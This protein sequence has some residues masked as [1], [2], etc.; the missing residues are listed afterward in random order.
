M[1]QY[2]VQTNKK[3][4]NVN[5]Q[6]QGMIQVVSREDLVL[7]QTKGYNVS[8]RYT[9]VKTSEVLFRLTSSGF[10]VTK[11]VLTTPRD[12][13]KEGF[14]K[15]MIRLSHNDMQLRGVGDSRPE[16]VIVN[17]HD[18]S[19]SIK[20]LIGIYRLVCANGLIVG[21]TFG[22]VSIRHVGDVWS[23][24]DSGLE[25]IK[26]RLPEV[27]ESI[28]AFQGIQL[29]ESQRFELAREAVKLIVPQNATNVNLSSALRV[30]R[31]ED[32]SQDLWTVFNRLQ[33]SAL[34]GGVKY[35]TEV[36]NDNVI[37]IKNNTTRRIKS[38]DRQV[39]VNQGLWDLVTEYSKAA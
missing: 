5:D 36:K 4:Y 21:Q 26:T 1:N 17:S 27:A 33:E 7:R 14:Q 24:I 30:K 8:D 15:H 34:G 9:A 23:K 31:S 13:T 37:D 32:S 28:Q 11:T 35:Q 29:T 25:H 19:T 22:G 10:N 39:E 38:I 2:L 3:R 18:A 6:N 12:K 16:I 20:M